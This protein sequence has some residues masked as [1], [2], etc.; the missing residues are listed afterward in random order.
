[1]VLIMDRWA[2]AFQAPGKVEVRQEPLPVPGPGQVAAKSRLAAISPGTEMLAFKG[3][4]PAG[5]PLDATLAGLSA[6]TRY[7]FAYGYSTVADVMAAGPGV[8]PQWIGRRVFAFVPHATH[9]IARTETLLPLPD[10]LSD[11]EAV[12]LAALE[13]AV[14]L[15]MDGRPLIG[16]RVA[17]F[18][19]GII[20]L[21]TAALLASFPLQRLIGVD[22]YPMR[23]A[24]ALTVGVHTCLTPEQA[25]RELSGDPGPAGP[26]GS[27]DL[28]YELSGNPR[29]LN[30]A[31][32]AAGFGS[33]VVIGSW[34][35]SKQASVDLGGRFHRNRIRITSSQVSTLDPVL[36]GRWTKARRLDTALQMA[37]RL[38]PA[39][40]IT[41]RFGLDQAQ[42]AYEQIARRPE[43][44]LQ[45]IFAF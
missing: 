8:G 1:M 34:Y 41:H 30:G 27:A 33:R 37:A 25:E 44:T 12:F 45:V 39:R 9:F 38:R 40:F 10:D 31:L 18:G 19:Q 20:G 5:L 2:L 17:V 11:E 14:T 29:A 6:E 28:V 36:T 42:A 23:R 7:P 21:L 24:A 22:L 13:T 15:V 35:G 26:Q 3:K 4:L 16:E 32:A 43:E